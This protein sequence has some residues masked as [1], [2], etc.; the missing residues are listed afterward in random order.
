[1][2]E[3][4]SLKASMCFGMLIGATDSY[5]SLLPF[6]IWGNGVS[7]GP[8]S[9]FNSGDMQYLCKSP[10][11]LR[12]LPSLRVKRDLSLGRHI[13]PTRSWFPQNGKNSEKGLPISGFGK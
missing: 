2:G 13:V 9:I 1:M 5:L 11:C 8:D 7:F 12:F 3:W 10:I 6:K 4:A